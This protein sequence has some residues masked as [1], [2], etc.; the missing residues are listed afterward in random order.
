MS[1]LV[2]WRPQR[3]MQW[4]LHWVFTFDT[5][6]STHS[7]GIGRPFSCTLDII[8]L[9]VFQSY[10]VRNSEASRLRGSEAWRSHTTSETL[11]IDNPGPRSIFWVSQRCHRRLQPSTNLDQ[12]SVSDHHS[13]GVLK[14][15]S[16][17]WWPI[18]HWNFSERENY[19]GWRS[20]FKRI[21][22]FPFSNFVADVAGC[23]W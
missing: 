9:L 7:F 10:Q 12:G 16:P 5:L 14:L 17:D 20:A 23:Q 19:M 4:F 3:S 1:I 11:Y 18:R 22:V 21:L 15:I 6:R 2:P 8:Y 13:L